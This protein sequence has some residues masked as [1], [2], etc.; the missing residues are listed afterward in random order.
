MSLITPWHDA[1][2]P[3]W[4]LGRYALYVTALVVLSWLN[5]SKFDETELRTIG[6]LLTANFLIDKG[7]RKIQTTV[8]EKH[9]QDPMRAKVL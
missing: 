8:S 5:A 7:T 2:H 4:K 3:C 6:E 1:H 9:E